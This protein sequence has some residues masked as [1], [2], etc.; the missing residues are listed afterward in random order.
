MRHI[1][2]AT[3]AML[4]AFT[5]PSSAK[6]SITGA[7]MRGVRKID[8]QLCETFNSSKCKSYRA[9]RRKSKPLK[10]RVQKAPVEEVAPTEA[11]AATADPTPPV[12]KGKKSQ[13]TLAAS[14]PVVNPRTSPCLQ[15]LSSAG[16]K[17]VA[18]TIEEDGT[19][20]PVESPVRLMSVEFAGG[21]VNFPDLP[22]LSCK[23]ALE[24][25]QWTSQSVIKIVESST[26]EKLKSISTGPGYECRNRN[27]AAEGKLSEHAFGNA[28]DISSFSLED[29]RKFKVRDMTNPDRLDFET[30]KL[31]R[32]S[33]CETFATVLGP[34]SDRNHEEHLHVDAKARKAGY[35]ICQ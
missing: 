23:F 27:R 3:A 5:T 33:A 6:D 8:R 11:D 18:A 28:V 9:Q 25:S 17:F 21:K 20:C 4:V 22:V 16:V 30:L 29:G 34:G 1:L 35:R 15:S 14:T 31:V 19:A 12:I 10:S 13:T 24:L 7:I 32:S 26:G 2:V